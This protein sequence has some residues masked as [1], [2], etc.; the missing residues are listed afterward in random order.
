MLDS[1]YVGTAGQVALENRLTTIA[2]NVANAG[3]VGF[4]ATVVTFEELLNNK[5]DK[6]V[7]TVTS[8]DETISMRPGALEETGNVLDFAINGDAW[9]GIEVDGQTLL[10]KDGRFTLN[11]NAELIT[12]HGDRVL[13]PGGA[14]VLLPGNLSELSVSGNGV[15]SRNGE[16]VSG[17]GLFR[18]DAPELMQRAGP[19]A[20]RPGG[21]VTPIVDG[22]GASVLQ[23]MVE[24]SNV[25]PIREIVQLITVQR[26]F[27][28]NGAMMRESSDTLDRLIQNLSP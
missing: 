9:F 14:P 16:P 8:G 12:I 13:D 1:V 10:T 26:A 2:G 17:I 6:G 23:G 3:T 15:I 27:E 28:Q 5:I 19:T 7:S 11:A 21:A 25:D 4:R 22:N 20:F 24:K 18:V